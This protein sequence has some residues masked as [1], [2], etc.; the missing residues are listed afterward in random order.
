MSSRRHSA[1]RA[2]SASANNNSGAIKARSSSS[3]RTA[4]P[5][6]VS[7]TSHFTVHAGVDNE[8]THCVV[9]RS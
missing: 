6:Q 9:F 3:S 1:K 2:L 7:V 8:T 4:C 5:D